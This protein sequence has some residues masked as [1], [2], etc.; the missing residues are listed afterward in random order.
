MAHGRAAAAARILNLKP[1]AGDH[2]GEAACALQVLEAV[3]ANRLEV[4]VVRVGTATVVVA[5]TELADNEVGGD[6]HTIVEALVACAADMVRFDERRHQRPDV[7]PQ[8][9]PEE[10]TLWN[11]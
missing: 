7:E 4:R 10:A 6:G 5:G 2:T 9:E 8:P 11:W 3:L 1:Q